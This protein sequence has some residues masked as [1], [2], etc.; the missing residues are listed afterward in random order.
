MSGTDIAPYDG[1]FICKA[2]FRC[3][4]EGEKDTLWLM[5]EPVAQHGDVRFRSE[6]CPQCGNKHWRAKVAEKYA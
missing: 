3:L 4:N 1:G 5:A 6:R 2:R